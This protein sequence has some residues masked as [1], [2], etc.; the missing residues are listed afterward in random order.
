[1]INIQRLKEL[2]VSDDKHFQW[3]QRCLVGVFMGGQ[4]WFVLH[5]LFGM[6]AFCGNK[7]TVLRSLSLLPSIFQSA[8]LSRGLVGTWLGVLY[9]VFAVI[10][11]RNLV[12]SLSLLKRALKGSHDQE[13]TDILVELLDRFGSTFYRVIGFVVLS[14]LADPDP[15]SAL[16]ILSLVIGVLLYLMSRFLIWLWENEK[17][18]IVIYR[19]VCH[20]LYCFAIAMFT[21]FICRANLQ[22]FFEGAQ[23][24]LNLLKNPTVDSNVLVDALFSYIVQPVMYIILQVMAL[25]LIGW[26]LMLSEYNDDRHKKVSR[27]MLV[28]AAILMG[29]GI[30]VSIL[31][32]SY[33]VYSIEEF[34]FSDKNIVME[35]IRGYFSMMLCAVGLYVAFFYPRLEQKLEVASQIEHPIMRDHDESR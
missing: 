13:T 27:I 21:V 34:L 2:S 16:T 28:G 11:V 5:Y 25:K 24:A 31:K 12:Q 22:T 30:L 3:I 18:H 6:T 33:S 17:M 23:Y 8:F 14:F 7:V 9:I 35:T 26:T 20:T 4:I 29:V 19:F 32:T 10:L 15:L 1:M